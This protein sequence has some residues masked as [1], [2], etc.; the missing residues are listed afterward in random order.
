M[1]LNHKPQKV[2]ISARDI[3][4]IYRKGEH[5][6]SWQQGKEMK[7]QSYNENKF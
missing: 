1:D 5:R 4:D 6:S 7:K 3:L 2:C